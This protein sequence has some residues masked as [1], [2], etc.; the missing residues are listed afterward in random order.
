MDEPTPAESAHSAC[1]VCSKLKDV[2]WSTSKYGWDDYGESFPPEVAQ[3][4]PA[5]ELDTEEKRHRHILV[6]PLC[7]TYYAYAYSYEYLVDGSEDTRELRRI[8][9]EEAR[10]RLAGEGE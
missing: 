2:E 9:A 5:E 10:R 1:P 6:C 8:P 3:L 7:G 4:V